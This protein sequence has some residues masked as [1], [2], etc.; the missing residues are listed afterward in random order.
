[1]I[2]LKESASMPAPAVYIRSNA[3]PIQTKRKPLDLLTGYIGAGEEP[4]DLSVNCKSYLTQ[5]KIP[6][7]ERQ[8]QKGGR[9][10][11]A[12]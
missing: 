12:G 4:Q 5:D 9:T 6:P 10:G 8:N 1:M 7:A 2:D 11:S 3:R